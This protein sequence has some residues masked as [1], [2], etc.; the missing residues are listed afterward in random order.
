MPGRRPRRSAAL[1]RLSA[2]TRWSVRARSAMASALI[3]AA[4][5]FLVFAAVLFTLKASLESAS[6]DAARA[7][8]SEMAAAL[9]GRGPAALDESL[10][11]DAGSTVVAQVLDSAGQVV[12]QSPSAPRVV[13]TTDRPAPGLQTDGG[14]LEVR[15]APADYWVVSV[16]VAGSSESY[17]VIVGAFQGPTEST[18]WAVFLALAIAWP[19]TIALAW[20]ATYLLVGRAFRPVDA[21]SETVGR[22]RAED[23]GERVP[24]PS[25]NDEIARLAAAM[26]EMLERLSAARQAQQRFV[27]DASHELRSPLAG[28]IATLELATIRPHTLDALVIGDSLLPEARRMQSLIDDLLL[29]A[30]ADERG[31]HPAAVDVDLDD[32]I[33][34]VVGTAR[35]AA[36]GASGPPQ[37]LVRSIPVRVS[38]DH[39]QLTRLVRNLVDNAVRHARSQVVVELTSDGRIAMVSVLDDGQGIAP[40]DRRR[41]LDRFV[42][43]DAGRSRAAGGAGLGLAIVAEVAAAH[44]GD[45]EVSASSSGGAC[46][47]VR[48]PLP[49]D[50]SASV[51]ETSNR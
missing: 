29:L 17:V 2:P 19:F 16:G 37:I 26:N 20:A 10:F 34:T 36:D 50:Q 15:D 8:A 18:V 41:V 14:L 5:L 3:L 49:V 33:D 9:A 39:H 35:I 32:I 25:S 43:L 12:R 23:G 47:A 44:G 46:F 51:R 1:R 7:Q 24:V 45:V 22:I 42:R 30:T 11:A 31:L 21:I 48:V 28:I 38:G 27:G 40:E 13:L 4:A 6:H